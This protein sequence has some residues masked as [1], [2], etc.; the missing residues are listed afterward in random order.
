MNDPRGSIWRKWDFHFHT[1]SSY[2]YKNKSITNEQIIDELK[3]AGVRGVVITDHHT[4]DVK[5]IKDL[6]KLAG[7]DVVVFPGIELRSDLGGSECIHLI[8]IFSPDCL[9]DDLWT[10]M[11]GQLSLTPSDVAKLGNDS[12]YV[13]FRE[14]AKF[15]RSQQ[16]VVSVHA[17]TKSNSIENIS[18]TPKFKQQIKKDLAFDFIDIFEVGSAE[19][20]E[21]YKGVVFPDIRRHFP[22]VACSD[23]HNILHYEVKAN[24]WVKADLTL[25][26]LKHAIVEMETRFFIGDAPDKIQRVH[27]NSTQYIRSLEIR[28]NSNSTLPESWFDTALELNTD[29]VAIIGNKGSG[30]SALAD[31]IGLLGDSKQEEGFSFLNT[32]KFREIKNNKAQHFNAKLLW[33]SGNVAAKGLHESLNK[34]AVEVVKYIPQNYLETICNE[35]VSSQ[36]NQFDKEL[37]KVIF[38]HVSL[39][40]RLG[41]KS[42]DEVLE[43]RTVEIANAMNAKKKE[44]TKTNQEIVNIEEMQEKNYQ[45]TL[46]NQL[47]VKRSELT[48]HEKRIPD[49]VLKPQKNTKDPEIEKFI[50][51]LNSAKRQLEVISKEIEKAEEDRA[52]LAKRVSSADT[53]KQRIE[54][55]QQEFERLEKDSKP[56][57]NRLG[58]EFSDL[59]K[60]SITLTA[61]NELR[62]KA[63][64][65]RKELDSK[66]DVE[67]P[68]SLAGQR[69]AIERK[70][71]KLKT[72][73]DEPNKKYAEYERLL[74][75]WENKKNDIVGRPS[76]VG[77]VKYYESQIEELK[78]LPLK[79]K[80]AT[81]R[82]TVLVR[83]IYAKIFELSDIYRTSYQPV[84]TFIQKHQLA[85][86]KF[87]L[88]FQVS[89]VET[90]L[91]ETFL[92]KIH[93]RISGSFMGTDEARE[94]LNGIV[95]KYDLNKEDDVIAFLDD[96]IENLKIDRTTTPSRKNSIQTQLKKGVTTLE[97]YDYL[98]SLAYLKPKYS[99]TLGEKQLSHLSPGEKGMLL[100]VFYLLIDKDNIPLVLDQPEENLDNQT[101]YEVLV[102][103]IKEAKNR[104]QIIIV[105]H[106]PNLAV[107]CDADQVIHAAHDKKKDEKITYVSGAIENT[108]INKTIVDILEGTK[109]AFDN[110]DAKYLQ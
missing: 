68:N 76:V 16:G 99:L 107:V 78:N 8:G 37:K 97:L 96:I 73:L 21:E 95:A 83:G 108:A 27:N 57:L 24:C 84:Q 72:K 54:N 49:P 26:G 47:K 109:K 38:S 44:L 5:R 60:V 80:E 3:K 66:L 91:V 2:D 56:E 106:N 18:N 92:E 104:R 89:I 88:N 100:L 69:S 94:R 11:Q 39:A 61:L 4:I 82:R 41:K 58:L 14:A 6:Q 64:N 42:L 17:G 98:F 28:K 93:Q 13:L 103:C 77:S 22:L 71:S 46:Q 7:T 48:A 74:E 65:D 81:D 43:A 52:K 86:D 29:L 75:V 19:S 87:N 15:I 20:V 53:L 62:R 23:N 102:P 35:I 110:R 12:V 50:T 31:I 85:K 59:V 55:F 70:I 33:H 45:D 105:T 9:L 36:E 1:P 90:N 79:L 25:E 63:K 101:V 30:K 51:D 10:K 34:S 32:R 40:D 67:D